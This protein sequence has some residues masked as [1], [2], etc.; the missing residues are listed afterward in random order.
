MDTIF[1]D[2]LNSDWRDYRGNGQ[3][4][5]RLRNPEW[6]ERFLQSWNLKVESSL[7]KSTLEALIDLRASLRRVIEALVNDKSPSD[8]DLERLNDALSSSTPKRRLAYR[9]GQYSVESI[10]PRRDWNWVQSEIVAS[11]ADMVTSYD[12]TRI[13]F[14]ENDDC[15]WVFYDESKSHSRRWCADGCGN[16]LKV[17]RFRN[18]QRQ[19]AKRNK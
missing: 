5:D 7:T 1:F 11:F 13:K 18:L 10:S 3:R 2:F 6:M 14:C 17:R 8:K 4:E 19:A 15:R 16:L 12:P 9:R